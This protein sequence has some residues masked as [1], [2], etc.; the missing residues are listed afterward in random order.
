MPIDI[1]PWQARPELLD[2]AESH[3]HL[4]RFILEAAPVPLEMLKRSI[5]NDDERQ[6]AQRLIDTKKS[7]NFILSRCYLRTILGLYLKLPPAAVELSYH[8]HGKPFLAQAPQRLI[9]FNLSHAHDRGVLAV[10]AGQDIGIDLEWIDSDLK[11]QPLAKQFF[12]SEENDAL[13]SYPR[14]KQ[15]RG[16]YRLWTRKEAVLKCLGYGFSQK[17]RKSTRSISQIE[18]L[19]SF[20]YANNFICT[21]A[22]QNKINCVLK[23]E[24]PEPRGMLS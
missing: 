12:S 10:T 23:L 19:R 13:L 6:R 20:Y 9:K 14:N 15:L 24:A 11:F 3:V 2:L 18:T 1:S 21:C 17:T 22:A 16:F 7:N 5:L 8:Q 4:W